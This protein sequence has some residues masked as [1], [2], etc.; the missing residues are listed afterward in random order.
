MAHRKNLRA[1]F[2]QTLRHFIIGHKLLLNTLLFWIFGFSPT[3]EKKFYQIIFT[4]RYFSYSKEA[5]GAPRFCWCAV[6]RKWAPLWRIAKISVRHFRKR[7]AMAHMAHARIIPANVTL[8]SR[9]H[10][11]CTGAVWVH[12]GEFSC[13]QQFRTDQTLVVFTQYC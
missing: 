3:G 11:H 6:P 10:R 4:N 1:P 7:C 13:M 2:L 8:L 12:N 9:L 5:Y